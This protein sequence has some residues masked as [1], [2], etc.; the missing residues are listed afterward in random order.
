MQYQYDIHIHS[1]HSD[2]DFLPKEVAHQAKRAGMKGVILSD[3]NTIEGCEEFLS[4]CFSLGLET[5]MGVEISTKYDDVEVHILGFAKKFNKKKIR[6]GLKQTIKEYDERMIKII[7][8]LH[9]LKETEITFKQIRR[10]KSK[11]DPVT[12]YDIAK[13]I[14]KEKGMPKKEQKNIE[15]IFDRG[16]PAFVPYSDKFMSPLQACDLI[17][18][19]G[20]VSVLAHPGQF[21]GRYRG[22]TEK[23][24]NKGGKSY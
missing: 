4:A 24:R 1:F 21:V 22:G 10:K 5:F 9:Q 11:F 2:G 23:G 17:R 15:K 18:S 19:A 14:A 6:T 7:N 20:G 3:H 13:E 16:G 8:K 12:K